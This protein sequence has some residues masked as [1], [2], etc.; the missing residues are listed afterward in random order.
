M[1]EPLRGALRGVYF[2]AL[3]GERPVD[4]FRVMVAVTMTAAGA[5]FF[6]AWM[7]YGRLPAGPA[8]TLTAGQV[9]TVSSRFGA[10]VGGGTGVTCTR[11]RMP[12]GGG[13]FAAALPLQT[14]PARRDDHYNL[15]AGGVTWRTA[16][17]EPAA[18]VLL[19]GPAGPAWNEGVAAPS[20]EVQ[21]LPE[22]WVSRDGDTLVVA[23]WPH[24]DGAGHPG[25][26]EYARARTAVHR[27][28]VL[29]AEADAAAGVF[30]V[31]PEPGGKGW[32][33]LRATAE[34][35]EQATLRAYPFAP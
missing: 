24:S 21:E 14:L 33:S 29:V 17:E 3:G 22:Q 13:V 11:P 10:R 27:D 32:V 2:G 19:E 18:G 7:V 26:A 5:A 23:A 9:G 34:G 25:S 16:F 12:G 20:V 4:G 28:G 8:R 15:D 1:G 30:E 35:L 6:L 31:P